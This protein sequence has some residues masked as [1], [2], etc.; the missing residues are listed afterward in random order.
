[1]TERT[2]QSLDQSTKRADS[3]SVR[4]DEKTTGCVVC[5]MSDGLALVRPDTGGEPV[6]GT[7]VGLVDVSSV[8]LRLWDRVVV[9]EREAVALAEAGEGWSGAGES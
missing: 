6:T 9:H 2:G 5:L 3:E 8:E 7:G 4:R 1:M